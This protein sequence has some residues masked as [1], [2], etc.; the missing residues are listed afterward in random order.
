MFATNAGV[1]GVITAGAAAIDRFTL[2]NRLTVLNS[3]KSG[4]GT[5]ITGLCSLAA[6]AGGLLMFRD[7]AM[8]GVSS[9]GAD[10]TS[11]AQIYE[12]GPANSTSTGIGANPA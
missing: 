2:F 7:L 10:A 8:V 5:A 6:S 4:S 1:L 3:I 11:K 9:L 12:F